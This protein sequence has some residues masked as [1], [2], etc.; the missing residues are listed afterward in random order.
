[1]F[2]LRAYPHSEDSENL[3]DAYK[4]INVLLS[5]CIELI[6]REEENNNEKKNSTILKNVSGLINYS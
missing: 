3:S 5:N 4:N 1:M 6:R 2:H